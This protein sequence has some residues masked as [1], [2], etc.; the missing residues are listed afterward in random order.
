MNKCLSEISLKKKDQAKTFA[1]M[2]KSV[3]VGGK[4]I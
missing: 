3:E 1:I 4:K 2:R